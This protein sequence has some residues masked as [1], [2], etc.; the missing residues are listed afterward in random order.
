MPGPAKHASALKVLGCGPVQAGGYF[1]FWLLQNF[2]IGF[3]VWLPW[4]EEEDCFTCDC[5][6]DALVGWGWWG[7]VDVQR[8]TVRVC[9][10][11]VGMEYCGGSLYILR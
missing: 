9:V 3:M 1:N 10:R 4:L 5:G 11:S 7:D 8:V 2:F 6:G